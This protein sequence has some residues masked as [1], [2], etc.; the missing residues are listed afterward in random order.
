M[1]FEAPLFKRLAPN[2]TG[3][4]VGHQ[5]GFLVPKDLGPYFPA[6]P[7]PTALEPAPSVGI[8]AILLND[9]S[10][11]A[12]VESVYQYQSWGGTRSPERRVTANL[13]PILGQA[14][15]G[16]LLLIERSLD[17]N[18]TFRFTL[19]S[20]KSAR[21]AEIDAL[22][23]GGKWGLLQ[24][25]ATPV[26]ITDIA[27]QAAVIENQALSP[28]ALFDESAEL[29]PAMRIA[30]SRAFRSVVQKAYGGRCAMCGGG[31]VNLHGRSEIEA[32]HIVGRG[33][34]G[35]DDIRNGLS[36]CRAHH[37][38]FDQGLIAI[39]DDRRINVNAE[40]LAK[41]E[42]AALLQIHD[43]LLQYPIRPEYAADAQALAWHR[44]HICGQD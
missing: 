19:V 23:D 31:L 14:V 21:F 22:T 12:S 43:T 38:A 29:Q 24:G 20:Q 27:A 25:H 16:D 33:A 11:V 42:N 44:K 34:L 15:G 17:D 36:L 2:D 5:A 30:R 32:A 18:D 10:F 39:S 37:W 35:A 1:N 41:P 6:L 4:A 8:R 9:T 7:D 13:K 3:Q 26:T 28:L 40:A